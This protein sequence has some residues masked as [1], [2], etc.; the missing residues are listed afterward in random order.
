MQ[1]LQAQFELPKF[2]LPNF[3]DGNTQ[4]MVS[5]NVELKM[6]LLEIC[7]AARQGIDGTGPATQEEFDALVEELI[8]KNPTQDAAESPLMTGTWKMVRSSLMFPARYTL[9]TRFFRSAVTLR[10]CA[11]VCVKNALDRDRL[12]ACL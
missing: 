2:N 9:R 11:V 3:G 4:K 6:K 1:A 8:T 7:S 5:N 10:R 12:P